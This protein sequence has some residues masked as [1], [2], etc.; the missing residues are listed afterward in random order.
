MSENTGYTPHKWRVEITNPRLG[1]TFRPV[2]K[3]PIKVTWK[4]EGEPGKLEF[5]TAKNGDL[6]YQNGNMAILFCDEDP[7]FVG[8]IFTKSRGDLKTIDCVAYDQIRYLKYKDTIQYDSKS[9]GDLVK[10][11]AGDHNLQVGEVAETGV[12]MSRTEEDVELYDIFDKAYQN[13]LIEGGEAFVLYDNV[14]KLTLKNIKDMVYRGKVFDAKAMQA[15][16]Y[17]NTIDEGTYNRVKITVK[18]DA[19]GQAETLVAENPE[20][21]KD[22]GVLQFHAVSNE[23]KELIKMKADDVLKKVDRPVRKL[24]LKG[25]LGDIAIRGGSVIYVNL[26]LGDMQASAAFWVESVT[27]TIRGNS[28]LMDMEIQ[29]EDFLPAIDVS[30]VF[31]NEQKQ[32]ADGGLGDGTFHALPG[33][34]NAERIWNAF[35]KMGYSAAATAG[36][37]GNIWRESGFNPTIAE[38]GN[39]GHGRGLCQWDVRNRWQNLIQWASAKGLDYRSIEAQCGF[40]DYELK[41][42]GLAYWLNKHGSL[43]QF[44]Q[45]RDPAW[46]VAWFYDVFERGLRRDSDIAKSTPVAQRYFNQWKNYGMT[47]GGGS[48]PAKLMAAINSTPWPGASLCATWVSRVFNQVTGQYPDGN[49]NDMTRNWCHSSNLKDLRPGMVIGCVVSPYG[50]GRTYG[51]I[52]IYAGGDTVYSSEGSGIVKYTVKKFIATYG[53]ASGGSQVRWGWMLNTPLS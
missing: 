39:T 13:T 1:K 26:P 19:A 7:V 48:A 41:S 32:A 33:N 52:A 16:E 50:L 18:D 40:V 10:M 49:G 23:P 12:K 43:E 27:H 3:E 11:V 25:V 4:R 47:V 35:R 45:A 8:W 6:S 34:T 36:I 42:G 51:H 28:H 46:A 2:L 17:T 24:A 30:G 14:G 22:W 9:Y 31:K 29:N 20:H 44:K 53:P 38:T 37:M 21:I 5:T 15:W